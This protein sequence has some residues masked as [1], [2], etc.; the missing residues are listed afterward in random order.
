MILRPPE[1]N[2]LY[3]NKERGEIP[4]TSKRVEQFSTLLKY[5][6]TR[7]KSN[8]LRDEKIS[9]KCVTNEPRVTYL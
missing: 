9:E 2:C 5:F 3:I 8:A 1:N 4:N 7:E 6:A